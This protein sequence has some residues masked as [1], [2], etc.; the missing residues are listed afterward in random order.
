MRHSS[1]RSA[2]SPNTPSRSSRAAVSGAWHCQA[3]LGD[4]IHRPDGSR[5]KPWRFL[6]T[7]VWRLI[8]EGVEFPD[9]SLQGVGGAADLEQLA[10]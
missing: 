2:G 6:T 9:D 3:R 8:K 7:Q 1:R 10:G 4:A 5:Y